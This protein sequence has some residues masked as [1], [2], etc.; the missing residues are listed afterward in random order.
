[1]IFL[2]R[3]GANDK[4][5]WWVAK[6]QDGTAH[7][8]G[9]LAK[10]S[11]SGVR[12]PS[13]SYFLTP[14]EWLPDNTVL[15]AGSSFDT[16]NIWAVRVNTD[17]TVPDQP[18]QWT[19]GTGI[20]DYPSAAISASDGA[21]RTVFAALN[22]ATAIWRIPLHPG[23]WAGGPA[24]R[25]F[26]GWTGISSPS[27]SADGRTLVF[28][29]RL[30]GGVTTRLADLRSQAHPDVSMVQNAREAFHPV[31][32]GDGST[33]GWTSGST[34]YVMAVQGAEPKEICRP[35]GP[36]THLTFDGKAALFE[37][38]GTS[39]DL[40]L[41]VRGKKP[42]VLFHQPDGAP[43]MQNSG[44]FSPNQRWVAFSGWHGGSTAKQILIVPVT[45]DGPVPAGQIV[46]VTDDEF[47]NREPAWS[48]DG[49]RIYF[50]SNRDGFEC[51]WARD[52]DPVSA[53]PLG[54]AFPVAHFHSVG[55]AIR[56]PSPYTGSIGL[57]VARDFLV[58]T[59]T[60]STGSIWERSTKPL[61]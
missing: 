50:L 59:L 8:T 29:A 44:R 9:L 47:A 34:G 48:P 17:G 53:R 33:I 7:P 38:P 11:K 45:A 27:L 40:Q 41:V 20:E 13:R 39:E 6:L 12:V 54:A 3:K 30:P 46:E 5:D 26:S 55:K 19:G 25:L 42:R 56:G 14:A 57:S 10:F 28:S 21:V 58:L 4:P 1:M 36:L 16:T 15:F 23:D 37:G 43:W 61:L 49:R 18:K 35:C 60:E 24:E 32:S 51:V 31:L 2:G 22:T 52:V